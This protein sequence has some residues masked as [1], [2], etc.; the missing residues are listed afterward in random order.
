MPKPWVFSFSWV[1]SF[2]VLDFFFKM[3]KK[4]WHRLSLLHDWSVIMRN[5]QYY[6][7]VI[8][9][10]DQPPVFSLRQKMVS[11]TIIQDGV[12]KE[13]KIKQKLRP[14]VLTLCS[15]TLLL[16]HDQRQWTIV[17]IGGTTANK[18]QNWFNIWL[19]NMVKCKYFALGYA[20]TIIFNSFK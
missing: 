14:V 16:Q 4:G 2:L 1:L 6:V 19:E 20:R 3:S 13:E 5:A 17:I 11:S 18:L 9:L 12:Y 10:T 7:N 15:W 8:Q